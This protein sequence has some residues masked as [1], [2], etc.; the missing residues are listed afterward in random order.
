MSTLADW[1]GRPPEPPH[2][3]LLRVKDLRVYFPVTRGTLFRRKLGELKAVDGVSLE[4]GRGETLGLVGESGSG[5]STIGKAI[6]RLTPATGG[7]VEFNGEDFFSLRGRDLRE[8]RRHLQMI[9]QD[10]FGSLNPRMTVGDIVAEPLRANNAGTGSQIDKRVRELL[11]RCGLSPSHLRRYPHEFS[12]GQRQRVAIARALALNPAF[13]VADE[14]VSALDL[15]IRAQVM[16]LLIELQRELEL[17]LLLI[18][19]DLAGVRH[20]SD[21]VAVMYLGKIV[22]LAPA[23]AIYKAPVHPYTR[24]LNSAVPTPDPVAEKARRRI[25]LEGDVPSPMNPPTGC[26]FHPRCPLYRTLPAD[27]QLAC[28]QQEPELKAVAPH[29]Q[30]ACHWARYPVQ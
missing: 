13:V 9:F 14:P 6:L 26:R 1:Q 23:Q 18:S 16:N 21:R 2:L 15:S 11:S 27:Q 22:E 20:L 4:I 25:V 29:H 12:G 30:S 19:H 8:K 10:P 5:K 3:P 28:R 7:T 24:A 17:S